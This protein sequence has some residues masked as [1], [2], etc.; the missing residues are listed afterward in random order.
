MAR[1][2]APQRPNGIV[3]S[4]I[5]S[6]TTNSAG[7]DFLLITLSDGREV[8]VHED[9]YDEFESDRDDDNTMPSDWAVSKSGMLY[10]KSVR[11]AGSNPWKF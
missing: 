1:L 5:N 10:K 4:S 9:S 2:T 6:W 8:A 7:T 3:I 11:A